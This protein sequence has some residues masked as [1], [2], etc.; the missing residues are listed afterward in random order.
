MQLSTKKLMEGSCHFLAVALHREF[1]YK[2]VLLA[3]QSEKS[4]YGDLPAIH[5][6]ISVDKE[7]FA[8]DAIGRHPLEDITHQWA[9]ENGNHENSK[10]IIITLE[11][12]EDIL[13]YA[14]SGWNKPLTEYS[15]SDILDALNYARTHLINTSGKFKT[16]LEFREYMNPKVNEQVE[17]LPKKMKP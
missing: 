6:A 13:K 16:R 17:N 5:H 11:T 8:I 15:D 12:E 9:E 7:G 14:G 10:S 3:D 4:M 2:I 1:G